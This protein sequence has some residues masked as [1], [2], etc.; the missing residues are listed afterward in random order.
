MVKFSVYLDKRVFV[1]IRSLNETETPIFVLY[2]SFVSKGN[3]SRFY[4]AALK[5]KF[6]IHLRNAVDRYKAFVSQY[7]SFFVLFLKEV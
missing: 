1:M 5:T 2:V 6:C 4:L 7:R 3:I